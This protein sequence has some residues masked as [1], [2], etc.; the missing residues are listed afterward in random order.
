MAGR[1]RVL[2][3]NAIPSDVILSI[4]KATKRRGGP[5]EAGT[6]GVDGENEDAQAAGEMLHAAGIECDVILPTPPQQRV[7]WT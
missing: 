1:V 2:G 6:V 5:S 4:L 3:G 7:C